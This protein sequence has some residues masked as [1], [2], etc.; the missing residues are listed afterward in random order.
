MF[1]VGTTKHASDYELSAEFTINDIQ[2]TFTRGNDILESLRT[3]AEFD[4]KQCRPT[5]QISMSNISEDKL[6]EDKQYKFEYKAELD[7]AIKRSRE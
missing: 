1:Y 4:T 7:K 3:L 6:G 2:R 5:L